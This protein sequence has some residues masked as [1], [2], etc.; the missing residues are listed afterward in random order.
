MDV[1]AQNKVNGGVLTKYSFKSSVLGNL[2]ANMNVYTPP[3]AEGGNKVP[4]LFYLSGLTCN[5]DNAAQKGATF[6][7]AAEVGVAIVFPDTS[8]RGA[9]IA[10][11]DDSYDFGTGAGFYVN[12]T[13]APW[14]KHYQMYDHVVKEIPQ[15]LAEANIPVDMQ[16]ASIFGHSMGGHGALVIYLREAGKFRSASAFSPVAHPTACAWGDK[17]FNGYLEGG[18]EEG[19]AYDATE[20]L[21]DAKSLNHVNMLLDCGTADNF[22]KQR[23]L[24]PEDFVEAAKSKGF[25]ES[26]VTLRLHDGYD[27]SYYFISTFAP[28]HIRW[29]AQFLK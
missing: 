13:K 4:V 5:E 15:K 24:L 11:E 18:L 23:L 26:S 19:K 14:N 21:R 16:R 9:N 12:A 8:P 3:Q 20:L 29:H 2:D 10:G 6:A 1:K 7:A 28:E 17:A 27:H 25:D 22:Y